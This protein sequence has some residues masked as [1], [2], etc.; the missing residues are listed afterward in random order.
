MVPYE[1]WSTK[2]FKQFAEDYISAKQLVLGKELEKME[3]KYN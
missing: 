2:P 3:E 1:V